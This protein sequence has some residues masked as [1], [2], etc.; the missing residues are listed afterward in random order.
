LSKLD[1]KE[2]LSS[3]DTSDMYGH[4]YAM[5][6][7]LEKSYFT[8]EVHRPS[9]FTPPFRSD[10]GQVVICGMGGSA[11]SGDIACSLY[12][13]MIP[14]TVVKDFTLPYIDEHTLLIV[15]S[16]SG[17]TAETLHCLNTAIS[18]TRHIM[19]I[20]SG[21]TL[22]DIVNHKNLW[23]EIPPGIPPRAAIAHLFASLLVLLE[24]CSIIP[25][26]AD[27]IRFIIEMLTD[28]RFMFGTMLPREINQA[29]VRAE[30]IYGK[31]PI[32]YSTAPTFSAVAYRWKCQINENAKYPA[33]C[34]TL[35]ETLHNEIE[36]WESPFT[37][38]HF[39][40]I[41]IGKVDEALL[42]IKSYWA[43]KDLIGVPYPFVDQKN[44]VG[45]LQLP[46]DGRTPLGD[47]WDLIFQGDILSYYLA[48]IN[49]VDPTEIGY[50]CKVKGA[51]GRQLTADGGQQTVD[52][53]PFP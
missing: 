51:D 26:Q 44:P 42:H 14:I 7:H 29:K 53:P 50:I 45:Y 15:I 21:G 17:N 4:I 22:K 30:V 9:D 3:L 2:L 24:L 41:F 46:P 5:P 38:K 1:N 25:S 48:I 32:I 52:A 49:N 18:K 13:C 6:D 47:I 40:P 11:I 8:P 19:A 36:A 37:R 27:E 12:Q 28:Y 35:P 16:Y 10:I 31:F 33:F 43:F 39:F 34:H 23:I 20:T